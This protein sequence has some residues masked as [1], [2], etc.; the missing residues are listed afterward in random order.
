MQHSFK[1][2]LCIILVNTANANLFGSPLFETLPKGVVLSNADFSPQRGS[3]YMCHLVS[4][5]VPSALSGK[6]D[7]LNRYYLQ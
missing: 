5:Q 1:L 7:M 6:L 4:G 3:V 2:N